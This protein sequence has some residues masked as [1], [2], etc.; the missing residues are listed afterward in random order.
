MCGPPGYVSWI[1]SIVLKCGCQKIDWQ[2]V[3]IKIN[4]EQ[5]MNL[6]MVL[7][8]LFLHPEETF[9]C[10]KHHYQCSKMERHIISHNRRKMSSTSTRHQFIR[11]CSGTY[12]YPNNRERKSHRFPH[13]DKNVYM[14][15][16][17]SITVQTSECMEWV[18]KARYGPC[19]ELHSFH[20]ICNCCT[21]YGQCCH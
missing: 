21:V 1:E 8:K 14:Y 13:H 5:L 19:Q 4:N 7:C 6:L 15:I 16:R 12:N 3:T 9:L 18:S 10:D 17:L 11:P 2:N 20:K